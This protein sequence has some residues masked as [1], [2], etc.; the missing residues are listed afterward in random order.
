MCLPSVTVLPSV[1]PF[2][3]SSP[4]D[5]QPVRVLIFVAA[6]VGSV[7]FSAKHVQQQPPSEGCPTVMSVVSMSL[8][9]IIILLVSS[10]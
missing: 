9:A 6:S 5:S 4:S 2:S 1:K 8:F 7:G 3:D 10:V